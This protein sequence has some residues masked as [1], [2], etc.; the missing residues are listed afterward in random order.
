MAKAAVNVG[1]QIVAPFSYFACILVELLDFM[2]VLFYSFN[3]V[4]TS[5]VVIFS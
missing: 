2:V 5:T 4:L 3:K 1:A